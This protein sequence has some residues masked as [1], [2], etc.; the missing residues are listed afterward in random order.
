MRSLVI[1]FA[2]V[3]GVSGWG[4]GSAPPEGGASP[5]RPEP[6]RTVA[7]NFAPDACG[8]ITG[9]V[10]WIGPLPEVPPATQLR[11]NPESS[12]V[13]TRP[14]PLAYA[15]RIDRFTRG[16]KDVVVYLRAV[17][18]SWAKPWDWPPVVVEFRDS[19]LLIR[20]GERT[21]RVGFVPQG[22][23]VEMR[24]AEADLN[25]LRG[26]GA[27][28]FS[29][30]FPDSDRPLSRT[31]ATC[32]RVHLTNAAG[33]YWQAADLFVCDH[34][35]YSVTDADGRYHFEQVP[36]GEYELVAWHPNWAIVRVERNPEWGIPFRLE[37]A[38]PYEIARPITVRRGQ[39]TLANLTLPR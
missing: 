32:G 18:P 1:T 2:I 28:F 21:T 13:K 26:R 29:L 22:G 11:L 5:P 15:P 35:Y 31:F 19:Q 38:P 17:E 9:V 39:T 23:T 6:P 8:S 34:P 4:C 27:A 12:G 36:A 25:I 30:A 3:A 24:S 20:Q 37:Y 10:T 16:V 33:K 14:I 7:T